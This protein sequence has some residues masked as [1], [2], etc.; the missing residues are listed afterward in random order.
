MRKGMFAEEEPRHLRSLDAVGRAEPP[1]IAC[2]REFRREFMRRC[3]GGERPG[4]IFGPAGLEAGPIGCRRTGR[5]CAHRRGAET[6]GAP[7]LADGKN[8][9]RGGMRARERRRASGRCA[10]IR[11]SRD[12]KAAGMEGRPARRRRQARTREEEPIASQAAEIAALKAQ[13]KALKALGALARGARRAPQAAGRPERSEATF[14]LGADD[15]A[16]S[17]S[18]AR[19]A[20]GVSRRGHCGW[21]AAAPGRAAREKAGLGAEGQAG[22]AYGCRG[23]EKGSRQAV[24]CLRRKQG[25]AMSRRKVQRIAR[26]HGP[27]PRRRKKNPC[28]PIGAGGLPEVAAS[29]ASRQSRRGQP[30]KAISADMACLP[31]RDGFSHL[32]GVIDCETDIVLAHVTPNSMEEQLVLDT[33]DQ[34]KEIELPDGIWACSDQGVHYT[35]RAY[36][37]K[38]EELGISQSMSRKACCWDNAPIESFWGRM[39]EQI[40]DTSQMSHEEI[41]T[42][43]DDYIDYYNNERGQARLDWLTP[44]EYAAKLVA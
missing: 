43:V 32:S 20:P 13:A 36:R 31:G 39:K 33:Y 16:S 11:A 34:L 17:A 5:A 4:A 42:L 35:A 21:M 1:R 29:A 37:D 19:E 22:A 27:A 23:F 3:H 12:R 30:P 15:P 10:A 38:L 40:G 2:S 8:P 7:C 28:R 24:D 41:V 26:R 9:A 18:A 14:R 44:M 25:A 6:K